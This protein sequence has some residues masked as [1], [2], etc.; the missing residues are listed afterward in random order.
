MPRSRSGLFFFQFR[1]MVKRVLKSKKILVF[2]FFEKHASFEN[3]KTDKNLHR[4]YELTLNN[5]LL[6]P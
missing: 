2:S 4:D 6:N 1:K 3:K 5:L